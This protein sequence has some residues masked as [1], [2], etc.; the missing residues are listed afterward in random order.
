MPQEPQIYRQ[1]AYLRITGYGPSSDIT[2][3]LGIT[4]DKEWSEGDAWREVP[5]IQKRYFTNWVLN[6]GLPETE[7]LNSHIEAVL[8]QLRTKR[9]Q[10]LSLQG[11]YSVQMVCVSYSLQSFSFELEFELQ[12]ALTSFGIRLW[13]DA[14]CIEQDVH[15]L[16]TDLREQ[17]ERE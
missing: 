13:F 11:D 10:I 15:E 4:P 14:Y 6:S 17:L 16:V 3:C 9:T 8:R 5:P 7:D 2:K 1:Y 12:K